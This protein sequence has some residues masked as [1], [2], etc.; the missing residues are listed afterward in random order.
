MWG[1]IRSNNTK[2]DHIHRDVQVTLVKDKMKKSRLR[3]FGHI[4]CR[5]P[6]PPVHRWGIL[7][8]EGVDR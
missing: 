8:S 3:L 4:M 2:S 1:S 5:P 6:D 7:V